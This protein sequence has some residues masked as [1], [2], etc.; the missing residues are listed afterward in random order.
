MGH[1][2]RERHAIEAATCEL[3]RNVRHRMG[4]GLPT[5]HTVLSMPSGGT[6]T[7][8]HREAISIPWRRTCLLL[9][10]DDDGAQ[11]I[12]GDV[13]DGLDQAKR[14]VVDQPRLAAT[15]LLGAARA[16]FNLRTKPVVYR[17]SHARGRG[18]GP[19]RRRRRWLGRRRQRPTPGWPAR[20]GDQRTGGG[21]GGGG[22]RRGGGGRRGGGDWRQG[23][24]RI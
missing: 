20:E 2:V 3:R 10:L 15:P 12:G 24:V 11:A 17:P 9:R 23:P 16:S 14:E 6:T 7:L 5:Q 22:S 21:G 19:G 18:L 13:A 1:Q 4:R 8:H